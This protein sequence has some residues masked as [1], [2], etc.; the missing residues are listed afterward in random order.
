MMEN[1]HVNIFIS[2]LS[3]SHPTTTPHH[4]A[5]ILSLQSVSFMSEGGESPGEGR[6]RQLQVYTS[7]RGKRKCITITKGMGDV[8]P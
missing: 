1:G 2:S 6:V 4:V 8:V 3:L 5:L 7:L